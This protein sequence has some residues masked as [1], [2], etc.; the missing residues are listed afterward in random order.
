MSDEAEILRLRVQV[1]QLETQ[2]KIER[3][4]YEDLAKGLTAMQ[5]A[6]RV[7]FVRQAAIAIYTA[8][9]G[10]EHGGKVVGFTER[11]AWE[12]AQFLWASKPEDC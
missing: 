5:R 3:S 6:E 11:T 4:C 7:A 12:A 9:M 1:E 2:L 8:G 10:I